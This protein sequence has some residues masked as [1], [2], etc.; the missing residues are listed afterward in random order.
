[1]SALG[2]CFT[3]VPNMWSITARFAQLLRKCG[4]SDVVSVITPMVRVSADAAPTMATVAIAPS[5][6]R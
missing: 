3:R 6:A 5:K 2:P 4:S 1:M